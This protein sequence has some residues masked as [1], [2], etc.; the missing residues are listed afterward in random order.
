MSHSAC[1]SG[2]NLPSA[3]AVVPDGKLPL[4]CCIDDHELLE[5][6]KYG[7]GQLG[8][9]GG[10]P[11]HGWTPFASWLGEKIG[12]RMGRASWTGEAE[13]AWSLELAR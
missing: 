9:N 11:V 7:N 1:E 8:M 13:D 12:P 3:G 5:G 10:V 4:G 2:L 6:G